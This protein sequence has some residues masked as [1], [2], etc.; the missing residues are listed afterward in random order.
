M[1][2]KKYT[3]VDS[4]LIPLKCSK[5][6]ASLLV[7]L[8]IVV[9]L[10]PPIQTM[11]I[12]KFIDAAIS[13]VNEN[14]NFIGVLKWI[15]AIIVCIFILWMSQNGKQLLGNWLEIDLRRSYRTMLVDKRARL[16]YKYFEDADTWDLI[17]RISEKPEKRL[18][19]AFIKFLDFCSLI[20]E[21]IGLLLIF[22]THSW[23]NAI[24][25]IVV[26]IP[27]F[28]ISFESGKVTYNTKFIT[29]KYHR[30]HEY[31]SEVLT[32]REATQER[33][34]F[35]YGKELSKMWWEYYEKAR[36]I[37]LLARFKWFVRMKSSGIIASIICVITTLIL[38]PPLINK[39]IKIGIFIALINATYSLVNNMTWK[40]TRYIEAIANNKEYMKEL[41]K[42]INLKEFDLSKTDKFNEEFKYIE[43][44]HVKFKYPG[45]EKYILN[46]FSYCFENMKK[47]ALIGINGAGKTTIVKLI[48]GLYDEYEGEILINGTDIRNINYQDRLSYISVIYQDFAK[49]SISIKENIVVGNIN[50]TESISDDEIDSIIQKV[51]LYNKI[52]KLSDG[53]DTLIGKINKNGQDLSGGEWQK[54]ALARTLLSD[55]KIWIMD[56]PTSAM[57]PIAESVFYKNFCDICDNKMVLLISHRLGTSILADQILVLDEGRLV[58]SGNHHELMECANVYAKMYENQRGWYS[59]ENV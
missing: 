18:K 38:I 37:E 34:I 32:S 1:K 49:Y 59:Y 26:G 28:I 7:L 29:Q 36:K 31:L 21:I 3:L 39:S 51:G 17:S 35:G 55:A 14:S 48:L 22:L 58:E 16:K 4:I 5:K 40:F 8:S 15:L 11:V 27:I 46:D 13:V 42:F 57:D 2:E 45:T 19:E 23:A 33:A 56:E 30:R 6:S 43:F 54:V 10:V 20:I 53:V 25:I 41:T 24:I 44:V 50:R 12:A 47:Y 52:N 9:G